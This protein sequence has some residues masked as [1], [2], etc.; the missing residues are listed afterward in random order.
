[1]SKKKKRRTK[2]EKA[3]AK[4]RKQY[5]LNSVNSNDQ[6]MAGGSQNINIEQKISSNISFSQ[7]Q[8]IQAKALKLEVKN[9]QKDL[10]NALL[11]TGLFILFI[12]GLAVLDYRMDFFTPYASK[13]A[14]FL[15]K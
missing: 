8:N 4:H 2:K 1:M 10:K 13:L 12:V 7:E 5:F 6:K 15:M 11:I 3:R 14:G 9:I